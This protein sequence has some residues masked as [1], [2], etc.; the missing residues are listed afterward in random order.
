[1]PG[2][3]GILDKKRLYDPVKMCAE[4]QSFLLHQSWYGKA[5]LCTPE[6]SFGIV[7]TSPFFQDTSWLYENTDH[8]LVFEGHGL[9]IDGELV[10]PEESALA[11][12]ILTLYQADGENFIHRLSGFFNIAISDN[13]N[14]K[15]LLYNDRSGFKHCFY[16]H[17]QNVLLFAPETKA[18]LPYDKLD[19]SIDEEALA[20]FFS[21]EAYIAE[22]TFIKKASLLPPASYLIAKENEVT[23]K[24]YWHPQYQPDYDK[25]ES[26]FIDKGLELFRDSLSNRLPQRKYQK[27][28]FPLTGGLD[29]R[30][31][32]KLIQCDPE[33]LHLYTHGWSGCTDYLIAQKVA[34]ELGLAHRHQLIEINPDWMSEH[35]LQAVWMNESQVSFRNA[36]LIGIAKALGPGKFPFINGIIGA[37]HSLSTGHFIQKHDIHEVD[38]EEVVRKDILATLDH[39]NLHLFLTDA[40][41]QHFTRLSKKLFWDRFQIERRHRLYC[42]QKATFI[43]PK[44]FAPR[45]QGAITVNKYFFHDLIPF[46]DDALFDL[47][48]IIPAELRLHHTL[49]KELYRRHFPNLASIPWAST[50]HNLYASQE[51]IKKTKK[52]RHF[53]DK[54]I[55]YVQ[56]ISHGHINPRNPVMYQQREVWLR[57]EK[58]LRDVILPMLHDVAH[59]GMDYFDQQ[60]INTLLKEYDK[61]KFYYFETIAKLFTVLAW[62]RLFCHGEYKQ[63]GQ[64]KQP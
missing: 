45:M 55:Q 1:M 37:H 54:I 35:A 52:Y 16:Y 47:F 22:S 63:Y 19:T 8:A 27:I 28:V 58:G 33:E 48:C 21:T 39:Q 3:F 6:Q 11:Q 15:F 60:K 51:T 10:A 4:M 26:F 7:S 18:F 20:T 9:K 25:P 13:K 50:G 49:Y 42:D 14:R 61:G 57:K 34:K 23:I 17:D 31:L 44:N 24:T 41:V 53:Q 62:F 64:L 43:G 36:H 56:R 29:S 2:I 32:L 12:K 30:L 5:S 40:A 46:V 38:D 59:C